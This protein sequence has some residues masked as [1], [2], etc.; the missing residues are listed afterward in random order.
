MTP[1]K[2]L[3]AWS[4][5]PLKFGGVNDPAEILLEIF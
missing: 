5:T 3:S 2:S 1:L 4:M